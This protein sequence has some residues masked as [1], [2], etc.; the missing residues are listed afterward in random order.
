M[1]KSEASKGPNS[2]ITVDLLIIV[3]QVISACQMV[4]E[5]KYVAGKKIVFFC[6]CELGI[7][8]WTDLFFFIILIWRGLYYKLISFSFI[9]IFI[10][11]LLRPVVWQGHKV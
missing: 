6:A 4:Y 10:I 8:P 2:V 9:Y 1:Y 11:G 7:E 3:A 5:E